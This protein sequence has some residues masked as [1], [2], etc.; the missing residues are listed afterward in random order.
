ME[1]LNVVRYNGSSGLCE[2]TS[3]LVTEKNRDMVVNEAEELFKSI[4]RNDE[5]DI[6]EAGLQ[7]CLNNGCYM[8][9]NHDYEE[10]YLRW[11]DTVVEKKSEPS[12]PFEAR[13]L[14]GGGSLCPF[15]ESNDIEGRDV[16]QAEGETASQRVICNDCDKQWYD[17]YTLT[18]IIE[19]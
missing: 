5:A 17:I 16:L 10:V 8:Q 7:A 9:E 1:I 12:N 3:F 4:I 14:E 6:D 19:A 15:C 13:Y 18:G 2:I 11:S